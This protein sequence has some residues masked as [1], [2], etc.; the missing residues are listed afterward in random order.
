[1]YARLSALFCL[2]SFS[3]PAATLGTSSSGAVTVYLRSNG[4]TS[5]G[6]LKAMKGELSSLL[7]GVGF[8]VSWWEPS[9]APSTTDGTLVVMDLRGV[10]QPP[11]GGVTRFAEPEGSALASTAVSDGQ[12]L[13][14]GW[15]DCATVNSYLADTIDVMA[16]PQ[17]IEVYGRALG[18]LLAHEIYHML[19]HRLDH[20]QGGVAKARLSRADL[21]RQWFHF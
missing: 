10:C 16:S 21:T 4:R 8:R 6:V 3:A 1:M 18:R 5:P 14:F 2:I 7:G 9:D 20:E 12:V 17:R 15:V 19:T 13:P 11:M